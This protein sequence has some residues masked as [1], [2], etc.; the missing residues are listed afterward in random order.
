MF[1]SVIIVLGWGSKAAQ[2]EA[3]VKRSVERASW[4]PPTCTVLEVF[5]AGPGFTTR[6]RSCGAA[7]AR[8]G[9]RPPPPKPRNPSC[10]GLGRRG[11]LLSKFK[12]PSF[13][14]EATFCAGG[15]R[16]PE[17]QPAEP[18]PF[19]NNGP[20]PRSARHR[21]VVKLKTPKQRTPYR[22]REP[23]FASCMAVRVFRHFG[24]SASAPRPSTT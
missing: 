16:P 13:G 17:S 1:L 23:R 14:R 9:G 2:R 11:G 20:R 8:S 10:R 22:L 3:V 6:P 21:S 24:S 5:S 19:A 12:K 15:R 4:P 7:R 18:G